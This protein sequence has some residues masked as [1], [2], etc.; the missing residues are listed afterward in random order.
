MRRKLAPEPGRTIY[1]LRKITIEP[2]FG[3]IKYNRRIDRFMRRGRAAAHSEWRL[4]AATHNLLKLPSHLIAHPPGRKAGGPPEPLVLLPS[5]R[6]RISLFPH[7]PTA[8]RHCDRAV[9]NAP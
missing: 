9:R 3:Q 1:A 4:V 8:S 6:G 5:P 2:V 7:F